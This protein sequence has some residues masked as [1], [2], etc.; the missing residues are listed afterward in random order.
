MTNLSNR[1]RTVIARWRTA[2]ASSV[3]SQRAML[4]IAASVLAVQAAIVDPAH[5]CGR[6]V[7]INGAGIGCQQLA[8][9]D[10]VVGEAVPDGAYWLDEQSGAWGYMGVPVVQ[11]YIDIQA[12]H[13]ALAPPAED[14]GTSGDWYEQRGYDGNM[15]SYTDDSGRR[16]DFVNAG[17]FSFNTCSQ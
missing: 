8:I 17:E 5:A 11:G 13:A 4:A 12:L 10:R 1:T 16:C 7:Y 14:S 15:G 3:P 2:A 9:L 6:T